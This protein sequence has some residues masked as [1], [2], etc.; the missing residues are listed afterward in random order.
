MYLPGW[1]DDRAVG[2]PPPLLLPLAEPV[3]TSLS[4]SQTFVFTDSLDEGLQERLGNS[5]W[6]GWGGCPLVW[7]SPENRAAYAWHVGIPLYPGRE[8][9]S[10]LEMGVGVG[11]G[12]ARQDPGYL[13]PSVACCPS[14][15]GSRAG[16]PSLTPCVKWEWAGCSRPSEALLCAVRVYAELREELAGASDLSSLLQGPTWW[17]PTALRSTATQPCPARWLPSLMPS[18]PAG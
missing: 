15:V 3:L 14:A 9:A 10:S 12:C 2:T 8:Q 7:E 11:R 6:P 1:V 17:S 18:W 16:Q 4:P 13:G 5:A